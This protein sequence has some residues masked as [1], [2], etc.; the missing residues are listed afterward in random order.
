MKD[1]P[2]SWAAAGRVHT[3]QPGETLYGIIKKYYGDGRYYR[4]IWV[5]NRKRL[6]DPR[7]LR[8]GM[9]LIIP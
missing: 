1:D 3:V 2:A 4:R 7:H 8:V 5:A 9:R 6:T